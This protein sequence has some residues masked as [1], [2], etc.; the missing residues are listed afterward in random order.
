MAFQPVSRK[1]TLKLL[2]LKRSA[3]EGDEKA[4]DELL[5]YISLLESSELI[6]LEQCRRFANEFVE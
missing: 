2:Q 5:K 6:L 1:G 3:L 4:A